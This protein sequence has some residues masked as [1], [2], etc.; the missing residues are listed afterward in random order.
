MTGKYT[1]VV[2]HNEIGEEICSVA[3]QYQSLCRG[4]GH[5]HTAGSLFVCV[6]VCV[7]S[8]CVSQQPLATK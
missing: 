2:C 4:R 5:G 1:C 8:Q 6:F 7:C 3:L